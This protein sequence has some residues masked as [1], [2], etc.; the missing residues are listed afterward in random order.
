M[1]QQIP[2][3]TVHQPDHPSQPDQGLE[4]PGSDATLES[5]H[6][7]KS[8]ERQGEPLFVKETHPYGLTPF[9]DG[10]ATDMDRLPA[11][12]NFAGRSNHATESPNDPDDQPTEFCVCKAKATW[13]DADN[14]TYIQCYER[15]CGK[16]F[17]QRCVAYEEPEDW[18]DGWLCP[19]CSGELE[20]G[21]QAYE[22]E[23]E[24]VVAQ[25]PKKAT[26]KSTKRNGRA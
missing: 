12:K 22:I 14:G 24:I 15:K 2:E 3:S 4:Q 21:D 1:S 13:I 25:K 5:P 8:W 6:H 10:P 11:I 18:R 7:A 9:P 16:W 20:D 17:H 23:E 19:D 26:K